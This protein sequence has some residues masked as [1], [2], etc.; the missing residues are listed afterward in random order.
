VIKLIVEIEES[1]GQKATNIALRSEE[2]NR[3]E[4]EE[5]WRQRIYPILK[6]ALNMRG[7]L[8]ERAL[9]SQTETKP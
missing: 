8:G 9:V 4:A 3:T 2:N 1:Q 7:L 6:D 5:F